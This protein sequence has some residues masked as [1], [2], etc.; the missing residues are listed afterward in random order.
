[1]IAAIGFVNYVLWKIYGTRGLEMTGFLG[2]LVNSSVTVNELATRAGQA[3][4]ALAEAAYRGILLAIAAM[5]V[6][7]ALLLAILAPA[8]FA[9][10]VLAYLSMLGAV[11][12]LTVAA[13]RRAVAMPIAPGEEPVHLELPFSLLAALKYGLFFL[14]LQIAGLL[15]ERELGQFGFYIVSLLGG[16]VSSA[17]SVAAAA[18]LGANGTI[19][20]DVAG[21]GAVM[22]SLTSVFVNLPLVWHAHNRTLTRRLALAV[23]VVTA[24]GLMGAF[25]QVKFA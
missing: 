24:V 2:G 1:L 17:S 5:L 8:L 3:D 6:R 23:W 21:A 11:A 22:A 25:L 16:L 13:G 12:V 15:A 10:S 14:G 18:S 9:T 7:N 20:A 19:S 4:G